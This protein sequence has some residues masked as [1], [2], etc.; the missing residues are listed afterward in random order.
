MVRISAFARVSIG[1]ILICVCAVEALAQADT[2]SERFVRLVRKNGQPQALETSISCYENNDLKQVCLVAAVHIGEKSYYQALNKEFEQYDAVLYELIAPKD[3]DLGAV[4]QGGANQGSANQ[5]GANHGSANPLSLVQRTVTDLLKLEFQLDG[6]DYGRKN[7]VH[8]DMSPD[9]FVQSMQAKNES[10]IKT[11]LRVMTLSAA[12]EQ[13]GTQ[14]PPNL[15]MLLAA[16]D[17]DNSLALKRLMA[18]QFTE[19]EG[20]IQMI[21]GP[22]G[23]TIISGRNQVALQVLARE[24][25]AGKKKLAIFYGGAH[26]WDME[27]QLMALGPFKLKSERWLVAWDLAMK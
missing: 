20:V 17:L 27:R 24:L 7:F 5:G 25:K 2:P 12:K 4:Q 26:M 10:F 16:L 9:E 22:E 6:I 18:E 19:I 3:S 13:S 1:V 14:K 11:F 15:G 23:S 8:A 21:N